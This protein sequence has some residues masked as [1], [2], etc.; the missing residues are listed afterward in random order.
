M[1]LDEHFGSKAAQGN[2]ALDAAGGISSASSA[3]W[4]VDCHNSGPWFYRL[5]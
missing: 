5:L 2:S 4:H 1:D 3:W